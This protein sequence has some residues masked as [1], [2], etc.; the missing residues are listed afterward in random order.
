ML[1]F[2]HKHAFLLYSAGMEGRRGL[3][4]QAA[5]E[6]EGECALDTVARVLGGSFL[7]YTA[8]P[9]LVRLRFGA[10]AAVLE[11]T[12]AVDPAELLPYTA[13]MRHY[14]RAFALA[15]FSGRCPAAAL[16]EASAFARLAAN[17]T[18][19]AE[20]L[21]LITAGQAFDVAEAS[22][23]A[24]LA[25]AGC[26]ADG[27]D[28]GRSREGLLRRG[29]SMRGS[30]AQE[31]AAV[32]AWARAVALVDAFPYMEPP[33]WPSNLR[34]CLGQALL[35]E[36]RFV[37]AQA[38]FEA[39]LGEWRDNGWSLKGLQLALEGQGKWEEARLV[40]RAFEAAWRYA[41][42]DLERSCF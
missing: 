39:D 19:R 16:V 18:T 32:G 29:G 9:W 17:A 37:E 22:L 7:A 38:V 10:W 3:A 11:E 23:R 24:R 28:G 41:D 26:G 15:S 34:A 8:W 1:Y 27:D 30:I 25:E 31:G 14:A 35:D 33:M 21:F 2:S 42:V 6:L 40:R 4:I 12:E 36:G 13:A 5:D 20:P